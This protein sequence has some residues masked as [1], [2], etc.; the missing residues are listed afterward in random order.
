[1]STDLVSPNKITTFCSDIIKKYTLYDDV[2]IC[3]DENDPNCYIL[4]GKGAVI[5]KGSHNMNIPTIPLNNGY[6]IYFGILFCRVDKQKTKTGYNFKGVS[7]QIFTGISLLFRAEWDNKT[8]LETKHPQPHWHIE[9]LSIMGGK[10]INDETLKFFEEVIKEEE[11]AID[12]GFLNFLVDKDANVET[13]EFNYEKF[14]FAMSSNWHE[15]EDKSNIPLTE[16]NLR[17]WL[18]RCLSSVEYQLK[19]IHNQL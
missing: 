14:H 10:E 4:Q 17:C 8:E 16:S 11:D 2:K 6:Y 1:M 3:C 5:K 13:N 9:P 12:N 7:L 15:K 19:Y 18:D